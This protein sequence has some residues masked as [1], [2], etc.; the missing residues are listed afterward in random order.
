MASAAGAAGVIAILTL[1]SRIVGFGRTVGESWVLGATPTAD[2]YATANNVPNVLFEVAA[3]GALAGVVVPL[4]SRCLARGDREEANRTASALVTWVVAVGVPIAVLVVAFAEPLASVL[5]AGRDDGVVS[6]AALLLRIFAVQVPLYGLSVVFSG[7][8][9]AHRRFILPALAPMLSSIVVIGAFA[10]FWVNGGS[11]GTEVPVGALLWL[12]W[13]TTA[14]VVAFTAPQLVPVL[15]LVSLRPTF[16]FP[17]GVGA[18]VVSMAS[19]GFGGLLAQQAAIVLIMVVANTMGGVGAFPIYRYAQALY[20]L[21]YAILAVPIATSLFPRISERAALPGRPGLAEFVGAS[22]RFVATVSVIGAGVLI[23]VAAGAARVFT[24]VYEM[25]ELEV[26]VSILAVGIVGYSLLYHTSRV[27]YALDCP[28]AVLRVTVAGWAVVCVGVL[29]AIPLSGGRALTLYVLAAST[30][31][32]MS[33]AGVL[34]VRACRRAIGPTVTS[35]LVRTLSIVTPVSV[36]SAFIGSLA[37]SFVLDL[38]EGMLPAM[39]GAVVGAAVA[40]AIPVVVTLRADPMTWRVRSW[41]TQ[42]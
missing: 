40:G 15:R 11:E 14:G 23:A 33:V 31:A 5:L 24:L 39:G 20:F 37:C 42:D 4:L 7:I 9:Q 3:G 16:R 17:E 41:A 6:M 36:L 30:A 34:G 19:A 28:G 26:V 32:G 12:G 8:L 18:K 1:F 22:I 25:P 38:G 29:S 35:G 13:G 10:M 27:L 21:P 2:A